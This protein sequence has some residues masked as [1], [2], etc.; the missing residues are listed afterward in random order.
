MPRERTPQ[1]ERRA[2]T[3]AALLR[4]AGRVF[5]E[6]GYHDATLE[7]VYRGAGVSRGALY[8][9]FGSKRE[10]FAALLADRLADAAAAADFHNLGDGADPIGRFLH[11][12][13]RDPRWL[14]LLLDFLALGA[15]D[16][17]TRES[18]VSE[19]IRPARELAGAATGHLITDNALLSGE[20]LAVA[21]TALINGL[22]IERAFDP[23]AVPDDLGARVFAALAAGLQESGSGRG[24]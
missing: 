22:A 19:F 5:A 10:L 8:H 6:H 16:D 3:R 14:P 9:Y 24:D 7:Q 20:E 17:A 1:H 12:V 15:R 11:R 13:G 4:A 2:Q 21:T 18:V 23:D